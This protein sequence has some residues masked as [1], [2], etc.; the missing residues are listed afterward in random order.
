M[1]SE[2]SYR[3]PY[4][5]VSCEQVYGP[6]FLPPPPHETARTF[7]RASSTRYRLNLLVTDGNGDSLYYAYSRSH[8]ARYRIHRSNGI[9]LEAL[10]A[11]TIH[12]PTVIN[13]MRVAHFAP[14]RGGDLLLMTGGSELT[15][16]N[17]TLSIMPLPRPSPY[18]KHRNKRIRRGRSPSRFSSVRAHT[19]TLPVRSAWGLAVHDETCRIA[20]SSNSHSV[21][22][23]S[24][25]TSNTFVNVDNSGGISSG[26]S[27]APQPNTGI[28]TVGG[29]AG[30][31][32]NT[33]ANNN[34]YDNNLGSGDDG[35]ESDDDYENR[36]GDIER[37]FRLVPISEDLRGTHRNNIPCVAFN[38]RGDR[39]ASAS[40]DT[41]FAVYDLSYASDPCDMI[42]DL[43]APRVSGRMLY[44]NSTP[45]CPSRDGRTLNERMWGVHWTNRAGLPVLQTSRADASTIERFYIQQVHNMWWIPSELMGGDELKDEEDISKCIFGPSG[46]IA[47]EIRNPL[48]SGR[49]I[50]LYD[51]YNDFEMSKQ[52]ILSVAQANID[53]TRT[54]KSNRRERPSSDKQ[55][56]EGF[57]FFPESSKQRGWR[58][59]TKKGRDDG[60]LLVAL[61]SKLRLYSIR[62]NPDQEE[63][64]CGENDGAEGEKKGL[65]ELVHELNLYWAAQSNGSN[66]QVMF[67][68]IIEIEE[69]RAY[70]LTGVGGGVFLIRIVDVDT[71][72]DTENKTSGSSHEKECDNERDLQIEALGGP[73]LF[74]ERVITTEHNVIGT[75]VVERKSEC[76]SLRSFELWILE[77][78][79]KVQCWD[80]CERQS[81]LDPS[82]LV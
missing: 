38:E 5:P 72:I 14:H 32:A 54:D 3:P 8:V 39:L 55:E 42:M 16:E 70:V 65:G 34:N 52:H 76:R 2:T 63:A 56:V 64:D 9:Q 82:G 18:P 35:D 74:V 15:G 22:L 30:T 29:V 4:Y 31:G 49:D 58:K 69:L 24:I 80:L 53:Y 62:E 60:F 13:N 45:L 50:V 41:T 51:D 6:T 79:G 46:E 78:D 48:S 25:T 44:Q 1:D 21:L 61:E 27:A 10:P 68:N 75:C 47:K 67:T 59:Q 28:G 37:R 77:Q 71:D 19:F 36:D 81:A 12:P 43:F 20:V 7:P 26:I 23:L 33:G 73:Q 11:T 17:G 66:A 57:T 40:I